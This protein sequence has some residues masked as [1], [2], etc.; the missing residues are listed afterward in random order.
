MP[1]SV[2]TSANLSSVMQTFY[3]TRFLERAKANMVYDY[4]ADKKPLPANSGK[5]ISWSRFTPL[6]A[7]TT[8]LTEGTNPAEAAMTSTAVTATVAEYGNY[9]IASSLFNLTSL[10]ADLKEHID[11]LGQNAGETIDTLI[12]AQLSA[13]ST[14]QLVS[15]NTLLTDLGTTDTFSGL[16][17][18]RA[19][20]TLKRNKAWTFAGGLFRGIVSVGASYDLRGNSEW[21]DASRYVAP[22]STLQNGLLGR[23][24]GVE[25]VEANNEVTESSTTTVYHNFICGAH[26]YGIVD[27]AGSSEPKIII[28]RPSQYDT[29]N[30]LN[31]ISTVAWKTNGFAAKVL[32]SN[33]IIDVKCG[34]TA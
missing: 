19:V 30:P 18:R 25:F 1:N 20:R 8:A 23:L 11:V 7:A 24:H 28:K 3:D 33:W 17:V 5:T 31:M 32:N 29:N 22:G 15:G 12:A 13:N 2:T 10:D 26:S 4:A 21:L 34:A 16:E 6:S 9:V 27:I 14:A